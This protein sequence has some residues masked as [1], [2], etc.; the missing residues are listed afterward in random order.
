MT[1]QLTI[2]N[3]T[4]T[5]TP[6]TACI[7]YTWPANGVTYDASGNYNNITTNAQG[8]KD[9]VTLQLTINNGAHSFLTQAAC[10]SYTWPV[11]N[12]TYTTIG[13]YDNITTN[14]QGC[15]DTVTLQ[16]TINNGVHSFVTQAACISYTLPVNN[17]TYIASGNYD[18]ITTNAQGCKDTVTLQLTINNG[19]HSFV[20][21]SACISYT[22]PVNNQTYST[23]CNYDNITTNAQGCK[24]TVTLQLTIN[25]GAHTFVTQA[26]CISY[27]WPVNNQTYT[28]SGNYDNITTNAQGC[29][30]TVTLQ[31]TINNGAR[32]DTVV[33]ACKSFTWN[34]D[35]QTYT[36]SGDHDYTFVNAQGCQDT[37]RLKLTI[38]NGART[39]TVVTA[40]KS[41]TWNRDGQTYTANG[42]HD[43]TFV[44]AQGCQHTLRLKLTINNGARTDTVVTAC[45]SFTW[46]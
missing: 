42:D 44:N 33:T 18:N 8:C 45:K 32:T 31:L 29:K 15:K 3:G 1:L 43:Y 11:N 40:C 30:D 38:N 46:N 27:T 17:Q 12:Q 41:F 24:D 6:Q 13:N 37:V 4:H 2:N 22:S 21:Q 36:A 5:I 10:I 34:R 39:D 19:V 25:N 7:S 26:A 20:T 28:N 14:A 23:P 35:G 16:L 9:T